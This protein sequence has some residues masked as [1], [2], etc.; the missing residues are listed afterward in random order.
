M[1]GLPML[2][3]RTLL[4]AL[5]CLAA[6]IFV[7]PLR[8]SAALTDSNQPDSSQSVVMHQCRHPNYRSSSH[9]GRTDYG[10]SYTVSNNVWGPIKI[11]QTIYSCAH[12]S[13]YVKARVADKGGAVQSY[14]SSQYTFRSPIKISKF[15]SL[16]SEFGLEHPPTGSGLDYEFAYDIWI[17]GYGGKKHT[18]LMIWEYNHGQRPAGS[19]RG[20]AS[21][22]G[23]TW[24]VWKSGA[25][26][27]GNGDIVT[28]VNKVRTKSGTTHLTTF[29]DY[30]AGKGW[31]SHGKNAELWQIDWG[32]ELCASPKHTTF[33]FTAFDVKFTR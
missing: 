22:D 1:R 15:S 6:T 23:A 12:N 9:K 17:N 25:A 29:L 31:L 33:D 7:V 14:P 24:E 11:S 19:K 20:T 26:G 30:S 2:H 8:S 32:A 21:F 3:L 10:S 18:E 27:K 28:F 4:F 13:F 16:T 5:L